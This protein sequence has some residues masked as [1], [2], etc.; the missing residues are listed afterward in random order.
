MNT[1]SRR[2]FLTVAIA[3]PAA[4]IAARSLP[5]F[6]FAPLTQPTPLYPAMDLSHFDNPIPGGLPG[7]ALSSLHTPLM[8]HR[9]RLT[10]QEVAA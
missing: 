3:L 8:E 4:A 1:I 6:A 9:E 10:V 7:S 2:G 5:A